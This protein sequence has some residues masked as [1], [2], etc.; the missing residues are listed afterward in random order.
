[1]HE[2]LEK[3]RVSICLSDLLRDKINYIR[4]LGLKKLSGEE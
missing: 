1:M 3:V 4:F 2:R